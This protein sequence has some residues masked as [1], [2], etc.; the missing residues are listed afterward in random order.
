MNERPL[1]LCLHWGARL[2]YAV[3]LALSVSAAWA[4]DTATRFRCTLVDGSVHLLIEDPRE[5]HPELAQDCAVVQVAVA[6]VRPGAMEEAPPWVG[7]AARV[8]E[9]P[10]RGDR[11]GVARGRWGDEGLTPTA[12]ATLPPKLAPLVQSASLRHQLDPSLVTALM[13]VESRYRTDARSP[14]GA[15]GLMQLMPATAARYGVRSAADL[16]D[17][18]INIDVGVRHLRM[19]HD[20]YDGRLPL[21]LAAY[22]AGEGAVQRY[23]E[24]VPP[25]AETEDYVRRITALA[26]VP[27]SA[28]TP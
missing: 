5:R 15:L 18:R 13:F 23:G 11:P 9:A 26:G 1:V 20:R 27:E 3:T 21:M 25:F 16:L 24:R 7:F 10:A 14:K 22:N 12:L 19:L 6:P 8:I 28:L 2:S 17:P 4:Q